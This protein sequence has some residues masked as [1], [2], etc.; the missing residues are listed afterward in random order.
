MK[1][2]LLASL[3]VLM[4]AS[5]VWAVPVPSTVP[6][7]EYSNNLDEGSVGNADPHQVIWWDGAGGAM[8]TF[9][10]TGAGGYP[11]DS[12]VDAL[13][14]SE[15]TFFFEV[16]G[17]NATMLT[18]FTSFGSIYYTEPVPGAHGT[19]P[20]IGIW[21]APANINAA[22]PPDDV[23]GLEVWGPA[24]QDNADRFSLVGDPCVG[25][26]GRVSVWD[27]DSVTK[28][29]SPFITAADLA[30][31]I[32]GPDLVDSIDLDAMM[33]YGDTII[34]SIAPISVFDGG[35][36]WVWTGGGL[37]SYLVHGGCTWDTAHS[38]R[39]HFGVATENIN[40]LEAVPEPATVVILGL[41]WLA[42]L[43]RRRA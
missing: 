3:C 24:V 41:G 6:G 21:A 17:N 10:Y 25:D 31:A 5:V 20:N 18:S 38:V 35:E 42:L 30:G 19:L 14:N 22:S 2:I 37:A 29:A 26:F 13:A 27:Y 16:I 15:D 11:D 32:G 40:A 28:T 33:T 39:D 34:F 23:D 8:D 7:K 4:A 1:K 43:Y 36:I 9:D 12:Q